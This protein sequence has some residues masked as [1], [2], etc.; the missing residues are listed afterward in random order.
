MTLKSN[1]M[2]LHNLLH[3][4]D[5]HSLGMKRQYALNNKGFTL[6]E[7]I[8]VMALIGIL[9]TMS[10]PLYNNY[11]DKAKNAAAMADIG[12]L[13]NEITAFSL[14]HNYAKPLNL[15]EI[16]RDSL[17]DPWKRPYEYRSTGVFKDTYGNELNKESF[18]IISLGKN[19]LTADTG[20]VPETEDDIARMN[21]GSSVGMRDRLSF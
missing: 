9:A 5:T 8:M 18:D 12:V 14:D 21:E 2:T 20:G 15:G 3:S 4:I 19:G 10:I 7:L 1:L 11:T 17:L 16:G 13:S 6:V